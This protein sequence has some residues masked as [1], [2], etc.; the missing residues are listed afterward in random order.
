MKY[1][2]IFICDKMEYLERNYPFAGPIHMTDEKECIH[3]GKRIV[4]GDYKVYKDETGFEFVCCPDA[5]DCSGT[6]I[7]WMDMD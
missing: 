3:C 2:E 4:V 1:E 7:D 6:L 5:P